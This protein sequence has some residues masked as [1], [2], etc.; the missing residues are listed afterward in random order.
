MI[1]GAAPA[2]CLVAFTGQTQIAWLRWLKPGFRHCFCVIRD[3]EHWLLYEP[4]SN[5]T[6]VSILRLPPG[7]DVGTWLAGLG[8]RVVPARPRP[9]RP[10]V[11]PWFPFTCVEA[12]KRVLAIRAWR[13]ITP[14][15]LFRALAREAADK[16][17]DRKI[18]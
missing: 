2:E 8:M 3:G 18:K 1:A 10:R 12:V 16:G 5:R 11:L 17:L 7:E 9:S 13:I 4:L 6:V 14:Y 15:Q